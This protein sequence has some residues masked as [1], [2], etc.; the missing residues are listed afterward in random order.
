MRKPPCFIRDLARQEARAQ[1]TGQH[2]IGNF[3][4][5]EV[6]RKAASIALQEYARLANERCS[7]SEAYAREE[8]E[9]RDA[10]RRSTAT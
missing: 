1:L 6:E 10:E 2:G 5:R 7:F 4:E 3:T 9:H 8:R